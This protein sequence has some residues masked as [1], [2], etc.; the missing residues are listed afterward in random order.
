MP[1]EKRE[2]NKIEKKKSSKK[3]REKKCQMEI[4]RGRKYK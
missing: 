2:K 4:H 1:R 3:E